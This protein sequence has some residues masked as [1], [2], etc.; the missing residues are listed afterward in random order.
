MT[1]LLKNNRDEAPQ[2]NF[3]FGGNVSLNAGSTT[4]V[5]YLAIAATTGTAGSTTG[6]VSVPVYVNGG[7]RYLR[8][9]TTG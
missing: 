2:G 3:T 8:A 9:Y 6:A 5:P 1:V 4:G 7:W